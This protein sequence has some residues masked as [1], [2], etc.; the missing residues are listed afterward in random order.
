M[1]VNGKET[2]L[3]TAIQQA[4]AAG[5][6]YRRISAIRDAQ[7]WYAANVLKERWAEY[8]EAILA[9][10]DYPHIIE[11]AIDVIKGR[12]FEAEA[13]LLSTGPDMDSIFDNIL[14]YTQQVIKKRWIKAEAHIIE[15]GTCEMATR[16]AKTIIKGP[17]PKAEALM[18]GRKPT[19]YK[20]ILVVGSQHDEF[21][22]KR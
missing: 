9:A 13:L 12:W 15:N 4:E 11:Y 8:E 1:Q 17:W 3:E 2:P 21:F 10:K 6:S 16:Y 20:K 5:A 18:A 14:Y 22:P 7:C 19:H